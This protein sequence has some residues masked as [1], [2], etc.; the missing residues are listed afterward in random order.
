MKW[1]VLIFCLVFVV[2]A[3]GVVWAQSTNALFIAENGKTISG[4]GISLVILLVATGVAVGKRTSTYDAHVVDKDIHT[5][6]AELQDRFV[7]KEFCAG[8]TKLLQE[9]RDSAIRTETKVDAIAE[10]LR[11]GGK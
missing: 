4:I 7:D 3:I 5:P 9:T 10:T 8:K 2:F 1:I 11:D 6:Q